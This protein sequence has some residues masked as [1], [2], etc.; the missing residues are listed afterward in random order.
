MG[1]EKEFC[2]IGVFRM[3]VKWVYW[4]VWS[5]RRGYWDIWRG[6]EGFVEIFII[7]FFLF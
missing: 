1:F 2:F 7:R 6:I 5:C 3:F 4:L